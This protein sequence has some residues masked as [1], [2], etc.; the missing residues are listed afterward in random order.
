MLLPTYLEAESMQTCSENTSSWVRHANSSHTTM[1]LVF[2]QQ[3]QLKT[4]KTHNLATPL[5]L[6]II[7]WWN[8]PK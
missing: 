8:K 3:L 1:A 7:A 2:S 5:P 4:Q 6:H